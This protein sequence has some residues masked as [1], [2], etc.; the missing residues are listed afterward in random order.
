MTS[1]LPRDPARQKLIE[2]Y[3][4][5]DITPVHSQHSLNGMISTRSQNAS[6]MRSVICERSN[7]N[8]D[9][10]N[11]S[12]PCSGPCSFSLRKCEGSPPWAWRIPRH[13]RGFPMPSTLTQALTSKLFFASLKFPSV[14]ILLCDCRPSAITGFVIPIGV[15]PI[16]RVFRSWSAAHVRQKV[17]I[18]VPSIANRDAPCPIQPEL[19]MRLS[20]TASVHPPPRVKL[21]LSKSNAVNLS[22]NSPFGVV[23]ILEAPAR[24]RPSNAHGAERLNRNRAAIAPAL[25]PVIGAAHLHE[26]QQNKPPVAVAP[27][28]GLVLFA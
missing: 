4:V 27:I 24:C 26:T 18:I 12:S 28:S 17:F 1:L 23:I 2:P 20:I 14:S 21:A 16:K 19:V 13:S 7:F 22:E 6:L 15:N 3:P 5:V 11:T 8:H 25:P 9:P 10:N